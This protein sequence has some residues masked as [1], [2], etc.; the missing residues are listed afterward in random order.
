[1]KEY[2]VIEVKFKNKNKVEEIMNDMAKLGW[3]LTCMS[4]WSGW[5]TG[6]LIA[7]SRERKED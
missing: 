1:M 2:K 3:E 7:F 6:L 5:S 4:Y